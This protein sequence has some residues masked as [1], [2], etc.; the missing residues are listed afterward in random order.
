MADDSKQTPK[1][2]YDMAEEVRSYNILLEEMRGHFQLLSEGVCALTEKVD[3]LDRKVDGLD[4]KVDRLELRMDQFEI[5]M[6]QYNLEMKRHNQ[7]MESLRKD[8]N[9]HDDDIVT[10]KTA[11]GVKA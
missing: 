4:R 8:I 9:R 2:E 11:V 3:G 1:S 6:L 10:L 5:A 7:V